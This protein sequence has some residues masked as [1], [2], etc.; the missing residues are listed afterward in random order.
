MA[1][2][3]VIRADILDITGAKPPAL[4]STSD[5]PVVETIP[6]A[7]P[8][9][10]V[11]AVDDVSAAPDPAATD[12]GKT[13]DLESATELTEEETGA[14]DGEPKK[15]SRGVQKKLDELRLAAETAKREA[16]SEREERLR[17]LTM[18]E[19]QSGPEPDATATEAEDTAPETPR[20][21]DYPDDDDWDDALLE[22]SNLS[23]NHIAKREIKRTI[24]AE[25]TRADA[26][27]AARAQE[28]VR[29]QYNERVAA[30]VEKHPDFHEVAERP[31][32]VVSMAVAH[33]IMHSDQGTDIQYYLGSNPEEAK[34]IMRLPPPLQLVEIGKLT[35]GFTAPA[36]V[37]ETA[38]ITTKLSAAP[39][40]I[41]PLKA[42]EGTPI[43]K[44]IATMNMDEY[45][46]HR[47]TQG[48]QVRP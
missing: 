26:E 11:E 12:A 47:K 29:V 14:P 32:V 15:Q 18:L 34:R 31:D 38:A 20:R 22:Y 27:S 35:S 8:R 7:S 17:L 41:R 16:Q 6:D 24:E 28:Q 30:A 4:S 9:P 39:A 37:A 23:A 43:V 25:R 2:M 13:T 3:Q 46:A 21:A 42:G 5:M 1:E 33:A 19:R 48:E 36:P 45:K 44:S 40:P 10:V